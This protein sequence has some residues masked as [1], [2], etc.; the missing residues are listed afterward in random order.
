MSIE[1][2][3]ICLGGAWVDPEH[4]IA[5]DS[6]F[7]DEDP[8]WPNVKVILLTGQTVYGT[9][10]SD[11]VARAIRTPGL[12]DY[13]EGADRE[14]DGALPMTPVERARRRHQAQATSGPV[15]LRAE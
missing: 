11:K 1:R 3:L 13:D 8:T 2:I 9:R 12:D 10:P 4:V 6:A 7:T 14:L 5:I 15:P